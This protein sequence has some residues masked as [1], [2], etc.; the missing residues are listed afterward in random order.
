MPRSSYGNSECEAAVCPLIIATT[1]NEI[2]CK[3]HVPDSNEIAIRYRNTKDC[4]KQRRLYC[5]ENYK[6]CEHY[7]AWKHLRWEDE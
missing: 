4:E 6:R 1:Q 2:R 7:I 3:S 5:E